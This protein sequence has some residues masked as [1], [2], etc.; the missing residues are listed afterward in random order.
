MYELFEQ[1]ESISKILL[2]LEN[3]HQTDAKEYQ[4]YL[5][6]FDDLQEKIDNEY[7]NRNQPI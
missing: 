2:T 7:W 5:K 1:Q 6:K 3:K 4:T